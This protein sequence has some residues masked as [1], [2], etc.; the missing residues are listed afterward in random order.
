MLCCCLLA[1][2]LSHAA[3]GSV[4][5]WQCSVA[6]WQCEGSAAVWHC[7][8]SVRQC[9][10]SAPERDFVVEPPPPLPSTATA[11]KTAINWHQNCRHQLSSLA[12]K[13]A[14]QAAA[15]KLPLS[16]IKTAIQAASFKL[17]SS[18]IKTAIQ[19]AAFKLPSSAI[20]T[21]IQAA[22]FKL[23][24]LAING[25]ACCTLRSARDQCRHHQLP[26]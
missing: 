18:A 15:I 19:A 23:P 12:I 2:S 3:T 8:C 26:S 4:T 9:D 24:S 7:E 16:A 5:V 17:P 22:A 14:I 11:I 21:A 13:T 6:V 20:K 25:A 10:G 1:R